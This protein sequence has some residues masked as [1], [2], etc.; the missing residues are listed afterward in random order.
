MLEECILEEEEWNLLSCKIHENLL[1]YIKQ[2]AIFYPYVLSND[3]SWGFF[4]ND[5]LAL[6]CELLFS[7]INVTNDD[8]YMV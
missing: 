3:V 4:V 1:G 5:S 2:K 7:S 8:P 6:K